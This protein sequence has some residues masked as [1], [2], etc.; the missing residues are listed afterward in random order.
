[1]KKLLS[2]LLITAMMLALIPFSAVSVFAESSKT[3]DNT[4]YIDE[5]G[6]G[7]VE[8]SYGYTWEIDYI[9]GSIWGEDATICTTQVAYDNCN[10]NWA[11][12]L[13]LEKQADG[14]YVALRDAIICPGDPSNAGIDLDSGDRIAVVIHSATVKPEYESLYPNWFSAVIA[15][16]V[17]KGDIFVVSGLESGEDITVYS[18]GPEENAPFES[19]ITLRL[20]DDG[21]HYI[22]LDCNES[23]AKITIPSTYNG[24]PITEI[25]CS[26]FYNCTNLQIIEIP[27][28]IT[29]IGSSAF[30]RCHSL[31][32]FEIPE[33]V[34]YIGMMAFAECKNLKTVFIPNSVI[35]IEQNAFWSGIEN[36]YCEAP[37]RPMW[38]DSAWNSFCSNVYW[39][40]KKPCSMNKLNPVDYLAFSVIAYEDFVEG[41]TVQQSLTDI[42]CWNDIWSEDQNIKYSELCANI[43]GWTVASVHR[44]TDTG[45]YAVAFKNDNNEIVIAFRGSVPPDK[46]KEE[47]EDSINDWLIN[48]IPMIL[49]NII[50]NQFDD[51][52]RTYNDTINN[53][54]PSAVVTTG[55][56]LGGAWGEIISAYSGCQ[57]VT[58]NSVP[59]LDAVYRDAV[60]AMAPSFA[61]SDKWN[62]ID[63]A[64]ETDI[65]AGMF[66]KY[67][68]TQIKP[69]QAHSST[70]KIQHD[71]ILGSLAG[72][73]VGFYL[74]GYGLIVGELVGSGA[75]GDIAACHG[76]E[77]IV[78]KDESGNVRLTDVEY[79][80]SPTTTISNYMTLA[81]ESIDLGVSGNERID[82]GLSIFT[83]RYSYGG[84]GFDSI[85][86]SIHN[87]VIVGGKGND[88]LDG[89]FGNDT[90]YYFKG[91]GFDTIVD[92]G[93]NDK[94]LLCGFEDKDII[95]VLDDEAEGYIYVVCND[96]NILR[97]RNTNR[98]TLLNSFEIHVHK[99]Q[100]LPT[101]HDITKYF[102]KSNFGHHILVACPVELQI[103]D[104]EGNVVFTVE[105][106]KAGSYYTEYGNFYVYEEENGEYGKVLDLLEGYSVK[107]V[108]VA[109]GTMDISYSTFENGELSE[110]QIISDIPVSE[111]F[112]AFIAE[113]ESGE[114]ELITPEPE[115][116][117][118]KGDVNGNGKVDAN[119]YAL[120]KRH[121]L[122]TYTLS[123]EM[124][125]RADINGNG[126]LE[127]SEY[128]LIKRHVLG[129]FVIK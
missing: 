29:K 120:A 103:I 121:C 50:G 127:A 22:V 51:A 95:S 112:E 39:N 17:K 65:L 106:G 122:K 33:S 35:S 89:R 118:V 32:R 15:K 45:F 90:Y 101:K 116:E 97:I 87:D 86:T 111:E 40:Y 98:N 61:G 20:S 107:V 82:K 7:Y 60:M 14:T 68:S 24:L 99:N 11:I 54:V 114:V 88:D 41:K 70:V 59:V 93:G 9:N 128:G 75:A 94:L 62:F 108:G 67:W 8:V 110:A 81:R 2:F 36:I 4:F 104:S 43:A 63:H 57:G 31:I 72:T 74:G 77:S 109:E 117:F 21:T 129:T 73:A 124:L 26:A 66:E 13:Y 80:F 55:H 30:L 28:S 125:M 100:H 18:V 27:E 71:N 85:T 92:A 16:S 47:P 48:D 3:Y 49:G 25:G 12:T 46:W 23:Y 19:E 119:D 79:S 76:L 56:S 58:F 53:F 34:R 126:K 83:S 64:N 52:I 38:W 96:K 69:Y 91:D 113:N 105:D 44:N 115:P 1:M 6:I 5:D 78:I 84:N 123:D 37:S 42:G 102:K 10:P